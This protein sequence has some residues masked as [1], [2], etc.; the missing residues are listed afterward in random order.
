MGWNEN[1]GASFRM[2]THA[3]PGGQT[4]GKEYATNVVKVHTTASS[5]PAD[6]VGTPT[7]DEIAREGARRMLVA[8]LEAEVAEYIEC[9]RQER[10]ENGHRRVVRNGHAR[11]RKLTM[12]CGT[13]EI[14]A[15]GVHD[16]RSERRFTSQI[17]PPSMRKSPA[18][19][20]VLPILYL[21]GLSTGDFQEALPVLL[22]EER[23]AGLSPS[24]IS[25]L[26]AEWEEEYRSFQQRDL[27][28]RDYVYVWVDGIYFKVRLEE[29]RLCTLVMI[30]V[31]PLRHQGVD[32]PEG[33]AT[34]NR[35]RAGVQCSAAASGAACRLRRWPSATVR[36]A[37][38]RRW[39]RCGPRARS[40]ETGFIGCGM[41]LDKLPKRLQSRAKEHLKRSW[42]RPRGR[43]PKQRSST[44][45]RSTG[46]STR[47]R[48]RR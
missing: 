20:E 43:T 1:G 9:H 10:D 11:P 22:A 38:G 41:V 13:V 26:T 4:G 21:R 7:L 14:A 6:E 18:V 23:S 33:P 40:R 42:R 2:R 31:R 47:R 28:E 16:R 24:V 25:R 27:S 44:S 48:S 37:S 45:R 17:L 32:R 15:P 35:G 19:A 46:R 5:T 12:G 34:V 30:G 39:P 29:D 36:S 8:A 3:T